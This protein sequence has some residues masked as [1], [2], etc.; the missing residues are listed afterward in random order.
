MNNDHYGIVYGM[1]PLQL[2]VNVYYPQQFYYIYHQYCNIFFT[3]H[4]P[5]MYL[6]LIW[7]NHNN[8]QT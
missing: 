4:L 7:A 6:P 8:S 1:K 3:I 5:Q 2:M